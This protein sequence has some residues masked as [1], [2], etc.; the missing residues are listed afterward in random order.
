MIENKFL[1]LINENYYM[2]AMFDDKGN[3]IHKNNK[4]NKY[5]KNVSL[6]SDFEENVLSY[7]CTEET[8]RAYVKSPDFDGVIKFEINNKDEY[9]MITGTKLHEDRLMY[10]LKYVE[11]VVTEEEDD[12]KFVN[13]NKNKLKPY[14]TFMVDDT[15]NIK[16]YSDNVYELFH[17][18]NPYLRAMNDIFGDEFLEKIIEKSDFLDIFNDLCIEYDDKLAVVTKSQYGYTIINVYPYSNKA[19]NK[20]EE[21][22]LLKYKV[23]QL[24]NEL[25]RRKKLID[26]Q[27]DMIKNLN[28]KTKYSCK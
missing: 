21:V 17:V 9:V 20:F 18:E 8:K 10:M 12:V 5:F 26:F 28:Q 13:L 11:N 4:F 25:K 14:S 27:K 15:W 6:Y 3:L 2:I 16:Y 19:Y 23:D 22:T 7:D 1:E 24:E